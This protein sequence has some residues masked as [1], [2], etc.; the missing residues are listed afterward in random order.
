MQ[1]A[2]RVKSVT[3]IGDSKLLVCFVNGIE[4][5]YDCGPLLTQPGFFLLRVPALF[6]A[7]RVDPGGYGISWNEALDLSE[8]ELWTNGKPARGRPCQA[9]GLE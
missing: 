2:P 8:Y 3:P 6:H 7:V 1:T 9:S 4:K 5:V